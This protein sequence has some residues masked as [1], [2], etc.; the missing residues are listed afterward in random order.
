MEST[1]STAYAMM[2]TA[3]RTDNI[4]LIPTGFK[5]SLTALFFSIEVWGEIKYA[6]EMTKVNHNPKF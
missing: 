1:V 2:L 4:D 5:D 3:E 6:I